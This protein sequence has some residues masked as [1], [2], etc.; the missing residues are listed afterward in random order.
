M[1][2]LYTNCRRILLGTPTRRKRA[3]ERSLTLRKKSQ[4]CEIRWFRALYFFFFK[5]SRIFFFI[6]NC[7]T[8][9]AF[10]CLSW[11][12]ALSYAKKKV[13]RVFFENTYKINSMFYSLFLE[14]YMRVALFYLWMNSVCRVELIFQTSILLEWMWKYVLSGSKYEATWIR[15]TIYK[16]KFARND[17]IYSNLWKKKKRTWIVN[18]ISNYF[19]F[20]TAKHIW[21]YENISLPYRMSSKGLHPTI[22]WNREWKK[23]KNYG[24]WN[25]LQAS[26][27][28]HQI[29]THRRTIRI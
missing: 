6:S 29:I 7:V 4:G 27:M 5:G 28:A 18:F 20:Y 3:G 15:S 1:Y 22:N 13:L 16:G 26:E 19:L 24:A 25:I 14:I 17:T 12:L 9:C 11:L 21:W 8:F 10:V 2:V 23:K